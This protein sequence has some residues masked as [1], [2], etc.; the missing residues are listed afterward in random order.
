MSAIFYTRPLS[1][2]TPETIKLQLSDHGIRLM[3][4]ICNNSAEVC[5]YIYDVLAKDRQQWSNMLSELEEMQKDG[6]ISFK[7]TGKM[8]SQYDLQIVFPLQI[9]EEYKRS[10]QI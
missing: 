7:K 10:F 5:K 8:P 4:L 1:A 3:E 2:L 9:H 6:I